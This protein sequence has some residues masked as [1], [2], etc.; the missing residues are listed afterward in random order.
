MKAAGRELPAAFI[1]FDEK[2]CG[3]FIKGGGIRICQENLQIIKTTAVIIV[4]NMMY[5]IC[6]KRSFYDK[7]VFIQLLPGTQRL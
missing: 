6:I 3:V 4:Y 1:S 5:Q 7:T 2:A